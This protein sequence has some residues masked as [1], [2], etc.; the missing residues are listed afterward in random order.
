M[1]ARERLLS[2][3]LADARGR[4]VVFVSHCL[5]NENVRYLGGAFHSGAVPEMVDL[6]RSGV[7]VVQLPCPEQRAWGGVLKR[8]LLLAYGMRSSP[9]Y[10]LRRVLFRLFV[11]HTRARYRLLARRVARDIADYRAAGV[12]VAGVIGVGASPSCGVSTTLDMRRSFDA[13]TA[14]PLATI[15][16]ALVNDRVVASCRTAGEGL[17]IAALRREL[18]RRGNGD[19]PF[20]EYDLIAEMRLRPAPAAASSTARR[21]DRPTCAA[22]SPARRPRGR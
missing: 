3:R 15:G 20:S 16:P 17:F 12:R 4:E 22:Q 7:G 1:T 21:S 8:R 6:L 10:P 19:I 13:M 9:L 18:A 14:C 11:W 5:L 2:E